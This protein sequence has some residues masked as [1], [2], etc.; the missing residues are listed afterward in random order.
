M[1]AYE[2]PEAFQEWVKE[3]NTVVL[4]GARNERALLGWEYT[5][6]NYG[7]YHLFYEPDIDEYTSI[8]GILSVTYADKYLRALPLLACEGGC[9]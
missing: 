7:A 1:L 4:L 2:Q 6:E 5:F 8:A 9:K 3:S